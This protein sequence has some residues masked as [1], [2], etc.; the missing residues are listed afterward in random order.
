MTDPTAFSDTGSGSPRRIRLTTPFPRTDLCRILRSA[1]LRP[2]A[3]VLAT[4]CLAFARPRRRRRPAAARR[5]VLRLRQ[6]HQADPRSQLRPLP[7]RDQAEERLPPRHARRAPQGRRGERK[8]HRRGAQRQEP[9]DPPGRRPRRRHP[10]AAEEGGRDADG[11]ADRPAARV[12]RRGREVS[13]RRDA[14]EHERQRGDGGDGRG[15]EDCRSRARAGARI[16][17]PSRRRSARRCRGE[18]RRLGEDADRRLRPR[19][20]GEGGP[21]AR[22]RGRQ[23]HAPPPAQPRPHRPAADARRRS[24]RSSP[25]TRPTPT[26]SRSSACWPRRTT[27]SAGAAT[28]STPPATP[29]RDGYEKDKPRYVWAYRDWVINALNRDLPYDQFIIEQLAGDLLP[30]RRRRTRSS[31]PASC[32]TR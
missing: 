13:R 8:G 3:A 19:A 5:A 18:E 9:A 17:G 16:T 29:T 28:G 22:A 6:G 10:D 21:R 24:T 23:G 32:A 31:P 15:R 1:L 2:L 20:A 11:A 26:R 12:D 7:R 27:A 30:E 14:G 25:T 4:A